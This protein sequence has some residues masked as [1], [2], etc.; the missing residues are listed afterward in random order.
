VLLVAHVGRHVVDAEDAERRIEA[1][2]HPVVE[3][4]GKLAL[5]KI[6]H[7]DE[8]VADVAEEIAHPVANLARD[9]LAIA[10]RH[11]LT[12]V[13]VELVVD[14]VYAAVESLHRV[15]RVVAAQARAAARG[16]RHQQQE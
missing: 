3:P 8:D 4:V 14:T 16:Q 6:V 13:L 11:R 10:L 7:A 5:Q 1:D 12:N 15:A 2:A 9:H